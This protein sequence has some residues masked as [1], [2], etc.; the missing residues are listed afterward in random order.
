[1]TQA[2]GQWLER[3]GQGVRSVRVGVLLVPLDG[4]R[5]PSCFFVLVIVQRQVKFLQSWC[6][7]LVVSCP[8]EHAG[9]Q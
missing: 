5:H 8:C 9:L 7:F 1:M 4:R 6:S 2:D 3:G